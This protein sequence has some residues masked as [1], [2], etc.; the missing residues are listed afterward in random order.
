MRLAIIDTGAS[1]SELGS[2]GQT[3]VV[4]PNQWSF[5]S[6]ETFPDDLVAQQRDSVP[7]STIIYGHIYGVFSR[8]GSRV[9]YRMSRYFPHT[10]NVSNSEVRYSLLLYYVLLVM[11]YH[12]CRDCSHHQFTVLLSLCLWQVLIRACLCNLRFGRHSSVCS[13]K[14]LCT[15]YSRATNSISQLLRLVYES[16]CLASRCQN[17]RWSISSTTIALN[18]SR[19]IMH[20]TSVIVFSNT[21]NS[22][23]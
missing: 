13:A 15:M 7:G 3:S 20:N 14:L 4:P 2:P 1:T 12:N 23:W 19:L 10:F 6:T 22:M 9:S 18:C 11:P 5:R 16:T 21:I 17:D 8:C